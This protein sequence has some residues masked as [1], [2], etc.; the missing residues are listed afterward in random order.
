MAKGE[1]CFSSKIKKIRLVKENG[2]AY[3]ES[4]DKRGFRNHQTGKE[5]M[6]N[7][8]K[9]NRIQACILLFSVGLL[10]CGCAKKT[11]I[12]WE[13]EASVETVAEGKEALEESD[14]AAEDATLAEA[15]FEASNTGE[16]PEE[17][18]TEAEIA[19]HVCGAVACPGV[20]RLQTGSRVLDAV[21][22]AGGFG[23]DAGQEYLNLAAVLEDQMKIVVP[24]L[25]EI[26]EQTANPVQ[27]GEDSGKQS[28]SAGVVP[29]RILGITKEQT[30]TPVEGAAAN[31][32]L[33]D[34][35]TATLEE[36]CTL[37]GI[38]ESRARSIIAYREQKGAFS[39]T[40]EIMQIRGIKDAMF[41]KIKDK[42][43]VNGAGR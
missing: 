12:L 32:C 7:K 16:I 25:E 14:A 13:T 2:L 1:L 29:E 35:N 30:E 22:A 15:G 4:V 9:F 19:V 10:L 40:E 34:L 18:E 38:G 36:L 33:V 24:T 26:R 37:P 3:N 28:G 20:Y 5:A 27:T 6:K 17:Q 41:Q 39:T 8:V 23:E 21:Q 11:E 31:N 42:I 43:T